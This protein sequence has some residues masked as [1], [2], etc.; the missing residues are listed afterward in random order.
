MER[1]QAEI[2]TGDNAQRA[3][4][5][6]FLAAYRVLLLIPPT[7]FCITACLITKT[8]ARSREASLAACARWT[9]RWFR[10]GA[11]ITGFDVQHRGALPA[12][13]AFI[14]PN[15]LGYCDI[16][17]IGSLVQTLFV[18]KIDV[19]SWPVM[20]YLFR[21]SEQIGVPRSRAKGLAVATAALG[22]RLSQNCSVCVFLE[23]TS[24]GGD[25]VR[26]F[27]GAL[28][29]PAIE[30]GAAIVPTCLTWQ[31]DTPDGLVSEDI[32]YWKDH[33]FA[34]HFWRLLGLRRVRVLIQ[35]GAPITL[36]ADSDRK[37]A[38]EEVRASVVALYTQGAEAV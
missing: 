7:L 36:A 21:S 25:S 23:G 20:G 3:R 14:A 22:E 4:S 19:E 17:A 5:N 35:F 8:T 16:I 32:A 33:A 15:H 13:G 31:I 18:A 28:L 29:Q 10:A 26:S 30:Q 9:H 27:H 2:H 34:A 12:P 6:P 11:R 37:A 38:A 24:S 1:S